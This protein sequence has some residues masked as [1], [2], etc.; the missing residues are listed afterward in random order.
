MFT[1][2]HHPNG[3]ARP[4]WDNARIEQLITQYKTSGNL[5]SLSSIVELTETRVLTLIRFYKSARY[6]TEDELL[7]D[8]N[9][10]L[11]R[12]VDK[13]D[14]TKGTAFT[15]L[16]RVVS[17]TLSTSVTNA[18]NTS[19]R[20]TELSSAVA[21]RLVCETEDK[22]AI[23]D[24]AHRI[25]SQAKTALTDETEL[26]AQRWYVKSFTQDGFESRRHEC[27]NAAMG[28][29]QLSHE[30]SRELY[31]LT[32]LEVRRILYDDVARKR[33]PIIPGQLHGTK[34]AWLT[35]Y[36]HLM[37]VPGEFTKF[38]ILMR[39]LAPYVLLIIDRDNNNSHRHDRKTV[40]RKNIEL[41]LNGDR[42]AV[43]LFRCG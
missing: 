28:V 14:P 24:I 5:E 39:D 32:M 20:Y 23:D 6:V 4:H 34:L 19:N 40:G 41:I 26:A 12:A 17:N 29:H 7:S 36:A 43:P 1:S 31:D 27:A 25:K 42:D 35:R 3:G 15:F 11:M 9:F 18:R 38:V 37:S 33:S 16:S 13:F 30:R 22:T 2:T 8:V 21:Q 10:K